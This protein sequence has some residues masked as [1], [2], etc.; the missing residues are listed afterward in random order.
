MATSAGVTVGVAF[1]YVGSGSKL[2]IRRLTGASRGRAESGRPMRKID[3]G[4][5]RRSDFY[6][7]DD[8]LG[9]HVKHMLS[10][11]PCRR[12]DGYGP[13]CVRTLKLGS[14]G[15]DRAANPVVLG[16]RSDPA[17]DRAL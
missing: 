12:T 6:R 10:D 4:V 13:G 3:L 16:V 14:V 9:M 2:T 11:R 5:L 1:R 7:D 8:R 15:L 17:P